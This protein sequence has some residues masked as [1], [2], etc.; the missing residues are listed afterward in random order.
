MSKLPILKRLRKEDLPESPP[1]MDKVIESHNLLV[2]GLQVALS[3]NL[4]FDDNFNAKTHDFTLR[5]KDFPFTFVHG[6]KGTPK[7]LTLLKFEK[8]GSFHDPITNIG[9]PDWEF[10]GEKIIIHSIPGTTP[11][12]QFNIRILVI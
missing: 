2:E 11:T 8:K 9:T 5:E 6:I 1:W 3:K 7:G 10:D 4:N 12:D